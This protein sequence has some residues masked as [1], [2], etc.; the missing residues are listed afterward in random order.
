MFTP[1][2]REVVLTH[3]ACILYDG[4]G[5]VDSREYIREM[6]ADCM[7]RKRPRITFELLTRKAENVPLLNEIYDKVSTCILQ[8]LHYSVP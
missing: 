4:K 6:A 3:P 5:N 8:C 7:F 2:S 1:V